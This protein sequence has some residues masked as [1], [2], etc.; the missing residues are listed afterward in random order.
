[1]IKQCIMKA[2]RITIIDFPLRQIIEGVNINLVSTDKPLTF[3]DRILRKIPVLRNLIS[4]DNKKW[5]YDC[6]DSDIII[7][8]DTKSNYSDY[9][10]LIEE[11]LDCRTRLVLY[12]WNPANFSHDYEKL[13]SR[14]KIWSFSKDDSANHG[15]M[16]AGTFY[17]ENLV[18]TDC[19][20]SVIKS[21][22]FFLG[23]EKGRKNILDDT[24]NI[25]RIHGITT[26][27]R[28]V[29]NQKSIYDRRYT[30]SMPY[31]KYLEN[32]RSSKTILEIVQINQTGLT[33]RT[34]ESL[35]FEKKLI[36]NNSTIKEYAFY[37]R[38]N[39]FIIGEDDWSKINRFIEEDY[40]PIDEREKEKY[41]FE[42]WLTRIINN[43]VFD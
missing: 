11:N 13:S 4:T 20:S 12:L 37:D 35:F 18:N 10:N 36:T 32:I 22:V 5:L 40:K 26:D 21:D 33:L 30:R 6:L 25:L 15:F 3:M 41:K 9:A 24:E 16:Y 14:W 38:R 29:D 1:M 7:L 2:N 43:I 39:I 28:I 23:T 17:N 31:L 42:N 27:I 19:D 34:M 8:F